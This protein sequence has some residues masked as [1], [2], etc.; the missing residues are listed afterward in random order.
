MSKYWLLYFVK[1]HCSNLLNPE[2]FYCHCIY[3]YWTGIWKEPLAYCYIA[4]LK[5]RFNVP[6]KECEH[7]KITDLKCQ[8]QSVVQPDHQ[9]VLVP[10][11]EE[12]KDSSP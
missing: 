11:C 9:Y 8:S 7:K 3:S 2:S 1:I 6:F 5:I 4:T 10:T 12:F